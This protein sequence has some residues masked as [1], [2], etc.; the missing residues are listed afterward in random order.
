MNDKMSYLPDDDNGIQQ[1]NDEEREQ[2]EM[3]YNEWLDNLDK[4]KEIN[5]TNNK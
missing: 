2:Y 1:M 5:A 3:E 4:E